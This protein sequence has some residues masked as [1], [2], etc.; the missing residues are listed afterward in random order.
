VIETVMQSAGTVVFTPPG[1]LRAQEHIVLLLH[2]AGA[3]E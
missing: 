3:G 2:G 1:S